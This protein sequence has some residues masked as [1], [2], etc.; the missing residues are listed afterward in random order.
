MRCSRA[1]GQK[2][3]ALMFK[4]KIW[5]RLGALAVASSATASSK[6]IHATESVDQSKEVIGQYDSAGI[7]VAQRGTRGAG[8]EGGEGGEAGT[9]RP[10]VAPKVA[11]QQ[12]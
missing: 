9:S 10:A 6:P 8:G 4:P 1:I 5:L 3:G 7:V 12:Q 11:P 2:K